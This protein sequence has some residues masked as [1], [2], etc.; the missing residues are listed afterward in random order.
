MQ[1][2]DLIQEYFSCYEKSDIKKLEKL[3]GDGFR[4]SS[5]HD[6]KLDKSSY[7]ERC[8]GFN[9]SVEKYHILKFIERN[10]EV[11]LSYIATTYDSR[12][13]ENAEYFD[14]RDGKIVAIN[15]YYGDLAK[16]Y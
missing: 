15:V 16:G 9:K 5:P 7:F 4:F 14:I 6:K 11:F 2:F 12:E 10:N 13:I 8:W 3:L 1:H